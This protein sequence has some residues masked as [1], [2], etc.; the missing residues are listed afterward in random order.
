M[1]EP[2]SSVDRYEYFQQFDEEF[3]SRLDFQAY[4]DVSRLRLDT[5]GAATAS[6]DVRSF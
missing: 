6:S 1:G 3:S 4:L 5:V 2:T